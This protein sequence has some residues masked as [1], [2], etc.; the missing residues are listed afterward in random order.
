MKKSSPW[1][2][3]PWTLHWTKK[4]GHICNA[5]ICY[6][7]DLAEPGEEVFIQKLDNE[8]I[9]KASSSSQLVAK[10]KP[11]D[12]KTWDQI[13]PPQ[14]HKWKVFSEKEAWCLPKH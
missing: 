2:S 5:W 3:E 9:R 7:E 1:L 11:Q 12:E 14:Y 8:Q 13:V 4:V 6:A 10:V